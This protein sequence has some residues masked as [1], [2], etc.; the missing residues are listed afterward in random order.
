MYHKL[1]CT[2]ITGH[3]KG[4]SRSLSAVLTRLSLLLKNSFFWGGGGLYL[5]F[6][7]I[8]RHNCHA[9]SKIPQCY[10]CISTEGKEGGL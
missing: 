3:G 7:M 5:F 6:V 2:Q 1:Y 4:S 8:Q 9:A 10:Y